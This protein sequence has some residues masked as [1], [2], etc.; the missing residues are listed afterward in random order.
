[1]VRSA[2][3]LCWLS[4]AACGGGPPPELLGVS[5]EEPSGPLT[6]GDSVSAVVTAQNADG[7]RVRVTAWLTPELSAQPRALE[8]RELILATAGQNDSASWSLRLTEEAFAYEGDNQLH[9][10]ATLGDT[11]VE[12]Q[13]VTF[14]VRP[15]VVALSLGYRG[16]DGPRDLA[17]GEVIPVGAEVSLTLDTADLAGRRPV[18]LQAEVDGQVMETWSLTPEEDQVVSTRTIPASWLGA[19]SSSRITFRAET[20]GSVVESPEI[21]VSTHGIFDCGFRAADGSELG[22]GARVGP[23]NNVFLRARVWG[24]AGQAANFELWEQD[25]SEDDFV[26]RFNANEQSGVLQVAW[27]TQWIDDGL[28]DTEDEYYFNVDFAGARCRS[29]LLVVP[30]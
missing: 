1:M 5:L 27:S 14:T 11:V 30:Q 6:K 26:T 7:E 17:G 18:Q 25:S 12:S 23:G 13:P 22:P 3:A 9:Y 24:R 21:L 29:G 20:P 10:S 19:G 2:R 28:L 4:L 8:E 15:R 16:P